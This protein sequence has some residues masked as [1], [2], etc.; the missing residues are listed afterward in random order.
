MDDNQLERNLISVG[1]ECFVTYFEQFDNCELSNQ[2]IARR[3]QEDRGYTWKSCQSRTGHARSIIRAGRKRD[4]LEKI[5]D[6]ERVRDQRI[7]DR[8]A[9]IAASL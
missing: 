9:S 5:R 6:S 3:I 2:D 7:R 1:K 4:A 8:A